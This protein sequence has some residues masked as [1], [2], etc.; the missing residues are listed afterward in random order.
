MPRF[1]EATVLAEVLLMGLAHNIS[2]LRC[3]S[4]GYGLSESD[5]RAPAR[6]AACP[7]LLSLRFWR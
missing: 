1:G 7:H 6:P 3:V 4:F 5:R 2:R